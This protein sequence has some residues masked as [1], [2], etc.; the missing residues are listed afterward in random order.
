MRVL[1]F[2]HS[3]EPGGVERDALRLSAAWT[4]LGIDAP[5]VL[6]RREGRLADEAPALDYHV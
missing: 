2:L 1:T 4:M 6:G 5:I 3:F